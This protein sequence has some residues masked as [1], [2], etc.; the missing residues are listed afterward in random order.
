MLVNNSRQGA[1]QSAP[2]YPRKGLIMTDKEV[3]AVA[4]SIVL[5]PLLF[6]LLSVLA[7]IQRGYFAV[8]GECVAFMLPLA[9]FFSGSV[10]NGRR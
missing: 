10:R 9:I 8:G 4:W 1:G 2:T 6:A 7:Y 5:S 3:A